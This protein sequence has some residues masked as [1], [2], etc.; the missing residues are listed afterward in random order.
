M[1]Y[2]TTFSQSLEM[3][4]A[5]VDRKTADYQ[6]DDVDGVQ[7]L[8]EKAEESPI[9]PAWSF[10]RLWD[11]L[12]DTGINFYEYPTSLSSAQVMDS[13]IEAIK[14]AYKTGRVK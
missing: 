8:Y 9:A 3:L 5:G 1:N 10:G 11:M 14:R 7:V 13:L 4:Q 12:H 6:Y 2:V